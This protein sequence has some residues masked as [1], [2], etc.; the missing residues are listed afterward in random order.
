MFIQLPNLIEGLVRVEDMIDDYYYYD[1]TTFSLRGKKNKRG[2]RL[3]DDVVVIVKG[4][5]KEKH[6][7]DF[8]IKE[9]K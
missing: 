6:T 5:C 4:A 1:E 9:D 8:E 7:V 3:G 2:Y